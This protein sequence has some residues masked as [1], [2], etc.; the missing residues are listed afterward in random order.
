MSET[1]LYILMWQYLKQK[2]ENKLSPIAVFLF[3]VRLT[4][5]HM[6]N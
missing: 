6:S 4:V 1:V 2:L 5:A 3:K